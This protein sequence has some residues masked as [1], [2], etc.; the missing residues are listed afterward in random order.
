MTAPVEQDVD[1]TVK[2]QW[3]VGT[4]VYHDPTT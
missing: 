3:D 4:N 1:F 2:F